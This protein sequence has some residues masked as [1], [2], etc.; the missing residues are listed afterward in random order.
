MKNKMVLVAL[1]LLS[2]FS[3]FAQK[4]PNLTQDIGESMTLDQDPLFKA[5]ADNNFSE[6]AR[7]IKEG[8]NLEAK[9]K[10]GETPL[11][12]ASYL[13]H[14]EV[15]KALIKAGADFEAKNRFGA[16]PLHSSVLSESAEITQL[17][18]YSGANIEAKDVNGDTPLTISVKCG[19]TEITQLLLDAGAQK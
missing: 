15:I 10:R 9:D 8:A 1:L 16:T 12:I 14:P 5:I 3:L 13:H 11:V 17:L 4:W 7:L 19:H 2:A 6:V 18:I